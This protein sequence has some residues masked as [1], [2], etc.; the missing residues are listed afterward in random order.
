ML[1]LRRSYDL[2]AGRVE[3][4]RCMFVLGAPERRCLV[5]FTCF[6]DRTDEAG[7]E[8]KVWFDIAGETPFASVWRPS[9]NSDRLAFFTCELNALV[10]AVHP[11]VMPVMLEA[12]E[13][14]RPL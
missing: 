5:P 4:L 3:V 14:E 9:K 7:A 13:A 11:E 1:A 6:C 8:R 10:G 12:N 2:V